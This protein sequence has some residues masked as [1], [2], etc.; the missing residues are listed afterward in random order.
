MS[1]AKNQTDQL[2]YA[3]EGEQGCLSY[4][5]RNSVISSGFLSCAR[6]LSL[7]QIDCLN[8]AGV[9]ADLRRG[10][11]ELNFLPQTTQKNNN[12]LPNMHADVCR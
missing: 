10:T 11:Y 6:C 9:A 3:G 7:T 4:D 5:W 8:Q 2:V 1:L 12:H